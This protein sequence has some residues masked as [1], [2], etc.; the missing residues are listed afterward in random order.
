MFSIYTWKLF[1]ISSVF[2]SMLFAYDFGTYG[3]GSVL[4]AVC[5]ITLLSWF[6]KKY[7]VVSQWKDTSYI[8]LYPQF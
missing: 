8:K 7:F 6:H 1:Q 2:A 5:R 4:T 3:A